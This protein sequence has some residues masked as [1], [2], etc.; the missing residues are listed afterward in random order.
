M[1][2][3]VEQWPR[4]ET[5][6]ISYQPFGTCS[7]L[8]QYGGRS[9][10]RKSWFTQES[11]SMSTI[12]DN[13]L[14]KPLPK[15][16]EKSVFTKE[17]EVALANKS[18]DFVVHSLKDLPST[19]PP[20]MLIGAVFRRDSPY[21][22]VVFHPKHK[23][24]NLASL[25]KGSVIGT[26]SLRRSAQLKRSFPHLLIEDVRGNL[27][28]R[29]SKLDAG[30]KYDALILAAAGMDRM[31]WAERIEQVL[32]P[33]ECLYA[34]GQGALAVEVN[35]DDKQT[36]E[37]VSKLI[38]RDTSICCAAERNFLRTLLTMTGAVFSLDG[39][40]C[41]KETVTG[42]LPDPSV[43]DGSCPHAILT[44]S[45]IYVPTGMRDIIVTAEKLGGTLAQA[46]IARGAEKVLRKAREGKDLVQQ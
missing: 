34:V 16:G 37:L 27:N 3:P 13:I 20:G 42:T 5:K 30:D 12:G 41:L 45:S 6:I 2:N 44:Q 17:L 26:S 35:L 21:D 9:A 32:G 24:S 39:T 7:N 43:Q 18:V 4:F 8:G 19:L 38:D 23:G 14:E 25:P 36:I 1:A 29:L 31:G 22:V 10:S 28:T 11:V 46:L 33:D 40:E 15:I